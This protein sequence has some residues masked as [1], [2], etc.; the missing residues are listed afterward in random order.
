MPAVDVKRAVAI[1]KEYVQ[2][3]FD[4]VEAIRL[5]E[6]ELVTDPSRWEVTLS[7]EYQGDP[8]VIPVDPLAKLT[9][10]ITG[11][12]AV[13]RRT[14]HFKTFSIDADMG[15]VKAMRIRKV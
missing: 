12:P 10:G 15:D 14:R 4:G 8:L 13:A 6:V 5:E 7:F 1:A 9:E 11:R 3:L 2:A